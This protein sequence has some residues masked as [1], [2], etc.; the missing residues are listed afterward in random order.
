MKNRAK[1]NVIYIICAIIIAWVMVCWIN[2]VLHNG[3]KNYV[4]PRWNMFT[5]FTE[6]ETE[7]YV[8]IDCEPVND[9][10]VVT[11]E[12]CNGNQWSYYDDRFL[13]NGWLV[14]PT[15]NGNAIINVEY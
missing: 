7:S 4:Y 13:S 3:N 15:F 5:W 10:Y 2:V 6:T 9:Y 8:V 12:D 1:G 11:I 14:K